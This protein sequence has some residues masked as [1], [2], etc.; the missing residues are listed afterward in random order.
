MAFIAHVTTRMPLPTTGQELCTL[1]ANMRASFVEHLYK[2]DSTP[3]PVVWVRDWKGN[4]GHSLECPMKPL[5]M[6][7]PIFLGMNE[8]TLNLRTQSLLHK[9]SFPP[10]VVYVVW[11]RSLPIVGLLFHCF[12]RAPRHSHRLMKG[13]RR[14]SND[15]KQLPPRGHAMADDEILFHLEHILEF[16]RPIPRS[17]QQVVRQFVHTTSDCCTLARWQSF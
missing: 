17:S 7:R 15:L 10:A 9:E 12:A 4:P 1:H 13:R 14:D 8:V 5:H 6:P 2:V 3:K 16:Y 11:C